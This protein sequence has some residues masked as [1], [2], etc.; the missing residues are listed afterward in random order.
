VAC[1]EDKYDYTIIIIW[2]SDAIIL[3]FSASF[4]WNV[5]LSTLY[6][7][8]NTSGR[9]SKSLSWGN[10][11]HSMCDLQ[12]RNNIRLPSVSEAA[13]TTIEMGCI[14]WQVLSLQHLMRL[15]Y[16]NRSDDNENESATRASSYGMSRNDT[17][18]L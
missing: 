12:K 14:E 11:R 9:G 17:S 7:C 13:L 8:V 16:I 18:Y 15:L 2:R 4:P 1:T 3:L 5:Y 6:N 10:S